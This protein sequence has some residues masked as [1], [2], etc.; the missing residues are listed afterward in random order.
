M[1]WHYFKKT[2]VLLTSI[3]SLILISS[4]C[5]GPLITGG[6]GVVIEHF[7]PYFLEVNSGE[8]V[9]FNLRIRNT[10]TA[11]A[12]IKE[13]KLTGVSWPG[14]GLGTSETCD[15][16]KG[17]L[18]GAVP[19]ENIR[20]ESRACYWKTKAPGNIPLN[21]QRKYHPIARITYGYKTTTIQSITIGTADELRRIMDSGR[22]LPSET[23]TTTSG[24]LA[25]SIKAKSPIKLSDSGQSVT[26]P[27]EISITNLA[28]G[29][30][31]ETSDCRSGSWN[32]FILNIDLDTDMVLKECS[33]QQVLGLERGQTQVIGC[34]LQISGFGGFGVLEDRYQKLITVSA[35]YGYIV[36]KSTTITVTGTENDL[37]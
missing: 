16:I 31:C 20:G 2:N 33:E 3:I 28:N 36:E 9:Q 27:I 19:S 22:S 23:T 7:A 34:K 4:G 37:F 35:E 18:S 13:I 24:P 29:I 32:K 10:G 6:N 15:N 26:F 30:V 8:D 25:I 12:D 21:I 11:D 17:R 5:T 14:I 1:F